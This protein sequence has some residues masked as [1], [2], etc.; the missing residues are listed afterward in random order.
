[1]AAKTEPRNQRD[2]YN[3]MRNRWSACSTKGNV[4]L[5]SELTKLPKEVAEYAILHELLHLIVFA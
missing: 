1:M 4:T 5:N 3:E 2:P